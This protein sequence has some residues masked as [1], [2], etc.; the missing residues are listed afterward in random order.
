MSNFD[1][2]LLSIALKDFRVMSDIYLITLLMKI[3][4][5][6]LKTL[7]EALQYFCNMV[8]L[9]INVKKLTVPDSCE[10]NSLVAYQNV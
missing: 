1:F 2:K 7:H 8:C 4:K 10:I 9:D 3:V 5:H 6:P